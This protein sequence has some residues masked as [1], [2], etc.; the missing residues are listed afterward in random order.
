MEIAIIER[1]VATDEDME[2]SNIV[3]LDVG[4]IDPNPANP[5]RDVGDVSELADSIRAQG[6]R[7]N[8]LVTPTPQGRYLLVIGHRR[9]AAAKLAGLS[10]VPAVVADLSEREQRELMLVENS[11][12]ADLTVIE[13][14]DGYQGLLDLG[15]GVDEAAQR[16]GRSTSLVRRRLKIAAI[17]E[18]ARSKAGTAQLSIDDWETIADFDRHPDL[19]ER[20]AEAAGGKNWNMAVKHARQERTWR[21][22]LDTA[23]AELKRMG[24]DAADEQP[25]TDNWYDSPKGLR[26]TTMLTTG[27]IAKAIDAWRDS[28]DGATPVVG[29]RAEGASWARGIALYETVDEEAETAAREAREAR[30][31]EEREREERETAPAKEFAR[32]SRDLR[33][34]FV[35]HL[36]ELKS[37]PK[38]IGKAVA[39]LSARFALDTL[40]E[41]FDHWNSNAEEIWEQITGIGTAGGGDADD[42]KP[43]D[44]AEDPLRESVTA[45][46]AGDPQ[47]AAFGLL[48]ALAEERVSWETWRDAAT[49]A[50]HAA[51]LYEALETFGYRT[52]DTEVEA[53]NG[54]LVPIDDDDNGR[55]TGIGQDSEPGDDGA[56]QADDASGEPDDAE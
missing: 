34:A 37:Q 33:I 38:G 7:Q 4:L 48:Y 36:M 43:E 1:P 5:R 15:V 55:D 51:P 12:R 18:N 13:E 56:S 47:R 31:R 53:L 19:Q 23:R 45:M 25:N 21:E 41:G 17:G 11:Q 26:R 54:S 29:V 8:L 32:A 42:A 2:E 39:M 52:S 6:I 30:W 40:T 35:T 20:L 24:I 22:W 27:D 50:E 49:I 44:E 46:I 9:L 16:T 14:A 10:R 3:M 28:H